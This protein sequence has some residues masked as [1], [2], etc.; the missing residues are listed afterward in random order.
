MLANFVEEAC[1]GTGDTIQLTGALAN[2]IPMGSAF[3]DGQAVDYIIEDYDG[4]VKVAGLGIYT[5]ASNT[6][7]RNDKWSWDGTDYVVAGDSNITLSDST[8]VLRVGITDESLKLVTSELKVLTETPSGTVTVSGVAPEYTGYTKITS[9]YSSHTYDTNFGVFIGTTLYYLTNSTQVRALTVD[10][11][12]ANTTLNLNNLSVLWS[13]PEADVG[14]AYYS[15]NVEG[16]ATDGTSLYLV[17]ALG[18]IYKYA[19][20]GTIDADYTPFSIDTLVSSYEYRR[21]T[22]SYSQGAQQSI[23]C[24]G[25]YFYIKFTA[26]YAT[27]AS[28]PYGIV[29]LKTT[30][31][32][33]V[34]PNTTN[35]T[36][37]HFLK[38]PY[39]DLTGTETAKLQ[40]IKTDNYSF[41]GTTYSQSGSL[42]FYNN[43]LWERSRNY[44]F[45]IHK[46]DVDTGVAN[47]AQI[48][49]GFI[50][51]DDSSGYRY[52][53]GHGVLF[54][55]ADGDMR[56]MGKGIKRIYRYTFTQTAGSITVAATSVALLAEVGDT[57]EVDDA[58][59]VVSVIEN[60]NL[61]TVSSS[62]NASSN[63]DATVKRVNTIADV[64]EVVKVNPLTLAMRTP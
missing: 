29:Y 30:L 37:Y 52:Y 48:T 63:T 59:A 25:T 4:I 31:D 11:E 64:V 16:M 62:L 19:T 22:N 15:E 60:E 1:T 36:T 10:S 3:S 49:N 55:D 47:S 61:V 45:R 28:K 35:S 51:A 7:A 54:W 40:F 21:Y 53:Y 32:G 27:D 41:T 56:M 2:K 18:I 20:D 58:T 38:H 13:L 6:I 39:A 33:V 46:W 34:V 44:P 23:A 5:A 50:Y 24:D 8:H 12:N 26:V 9:P 42:Y 57:I 43:R 14:T 17:T